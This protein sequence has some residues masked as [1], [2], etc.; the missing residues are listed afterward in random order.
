MVAKLRTFPR[1]PGLALYRGFLPNTPRV[2]AAALRCS[3]RAHELAAGGVP[4]HSPAHNLAREARFVRV[5]VPGAAGEAEGEHFAA[6]GDGHRLTYFRGNKNVPPLDLPPDWLASLGTLPSVADG[7][8]AARQAR[9]WSS[10]GQLKWRMTLN[11][12]PTGTSERPGFPWHRDLV[13]NGAVTMIL[14][15]AAPGRLQF[16][17]LPD[18]AD[19][20]GGLVTLAPSRRAVA[21][22]AT[23]IQ[24]GAKIAVVESMTL[25]PGDLLVISG[26]ARWEFVHRVA[27]GGGTERVSL[28]YGCW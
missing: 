26:P 25:D 20:R 10:A 19:G 1:V 15:L 14:A 24:R 3:A 9:G 13:A 17:I 5:R 23:A 27:Q 6:Y 22:A 12:Y 8:A 11:H 16:G 28:V 4:E 21:S 7:V 2:L 18:H